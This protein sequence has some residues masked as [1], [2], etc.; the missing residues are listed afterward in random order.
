MSIA[1]LIITDGRDEELAATITSA[2]DNLCGPV[3]ERWMFDDTGDANHR[4]ALAR[5]YPA[6]AV[7]GEAQR[8]GFGGAIRCAWAHLAT[9]C[10]ARWVFHLEADFTFT[11]PVNLAAM[12][13][14]LS[15][16][17][18]LVQMALRR[19]AWNDAE[20]AAGGV[21][22]QHPHAYTPHHDEAGNTWLEHRLFYTTNPSLYRVSLCATGWPHGAHS[23]GVMTHRLLNTGSPEVPAHWVRFGYWGQREDQPWVTHIGTTRAGEGY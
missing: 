8:Q 16:N 18:V 9:H 2:A 3:S 7:L 22:E 20:R 15:R 11:R 17:P 14:V 10:K 4:A 19:Q 13:T 21:V 23:E 6:Y 1:L 12:S 5:R